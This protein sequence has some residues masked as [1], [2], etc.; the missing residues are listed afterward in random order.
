MEAVSGSLLHS[1]ISFLLSPGKFIQPLVNQISG[2]EMIKR[3][4]KEEEERQ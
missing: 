1:L 4:V 3:E 2:P